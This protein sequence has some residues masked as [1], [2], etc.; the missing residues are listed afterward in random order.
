MKRFLTVS[1][2][3]LAICSLTSL[4]LAEDGF[5]PLFNGK[6]LDGWIKRGGDATYVVEDDCIV[7]KRGD[8]PNTFLCTEKVFGNFI[9]K[10]DVKYD[11]LI[12]SG[13]QIR[14]QARPNGDREVVYGYQC[15]IADIE[16][17]SGA[18]YGESERNRWLDNFESPGLD[19]EAA[20]NAFKLDDW[21]NF[22]IQ[23]IGPT[24]RTW[25]NGVPCANYFDTAYLSGFIGLQIHSSP[26][27]GQVRW[28]NIEI[29]PLAASGWIPLFGKKDFS[30]LWVSPAG[31]WKMD[32]E[33][34][35]HAYSTKDQTQDGM[36]KTMEPYKDF[37]ARVTFKQIVGNSG[38]YFRAVEV[39]K[40]HWL[41]GFQDEIDDKATGSL[42]EVGYR[43][44]KRGRG[45]VKQNFETADKVFK[46]GDWNEICIVAIGD[47]LV[48]ILNG[49][50]IVNIIDPECLK[51][52]KFAL[53]LHS[54]EN[55]EY[56]FKDFEVLPV[57]AEQR[58]LIER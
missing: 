26:N 35:V 58:A 21:N 18:I 56:Y 49:Q 1:L 50:E 5:F 38:L 15:E 23:C 54:G 48:T 43:D 51:E 33:G 2:F 11:I 25:I 24:V 45:W 28:K 42:W 37:A 16:K 8:G 10:F 39:D 20:R 27:D 44:D 9:L 32:D 31:V 13:V 19:V 47:R 17:T 12:N 22:E 6:N 52:G 4:A 40:P 46:R 53:Q 57:C 36:V 7:G 3:F 14:S 34:I 55:T 29:K 41:G 30:D